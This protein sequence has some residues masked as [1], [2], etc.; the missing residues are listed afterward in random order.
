MNELATQAQDPL[1]AILADP[2]QLKEIPIETV[3]RLFALKERHDDRQA[4][5]EFNSCF[6]S[7]HN[8]KCRQSKNSVKPM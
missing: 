3:E 8:S 1:S 5:R 4:E 7:L 2:K 6:C